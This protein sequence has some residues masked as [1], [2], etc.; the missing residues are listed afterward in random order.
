MISAHAVSLGSYGEVIN[1]ELL[2]ATLL[3]AQPLAPQDAARVRT[4]RRHVDALRSAL[5]CVM[6]D[7][8]A[9]PL[10]VA[11]APNGRPHVLDGT[12]DVS[13]SH[14]G[15]WVIA[16][17]IVGEGVR[18]GVDVVC[19]AELPTETEERAHLR[20]RFHDDEWAAL[21]RHSDPRALA[22]A[23]SVKEAHAKVCV[24]P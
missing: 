11:R 6:M 17:G 12:R 16:A 4:R 23:W 1:A 10:E 14:H 3:A 24:P 18:V 20:R 19:L 5:T 2:L 22:V 9:A 21:E 13:A 7:G 15:S 8:L